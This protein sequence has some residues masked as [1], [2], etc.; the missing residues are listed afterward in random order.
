MKAERFREEW[1]WVEPVA[2][3]LSAVI[4]GS[5]W[6]QLPSALAQLMPH[7]A[8]IKIKRMTRQPRLWQGAYE[9]LVQDG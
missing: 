4:Y 9:R 1:R 3:E 8:D 7:F 2:D 6:D 5:Q